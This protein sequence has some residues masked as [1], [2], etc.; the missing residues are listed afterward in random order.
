MKQ[1]IQELYTYFIIFLKEQCL[2]SIGPF[3]IDPVISCHTLQKGK[4]KLHEEWPFFRCG[5]EPPAVAEASTT[6]TTTPEEEEEEE[7]QQQKKAATTTPKDIW[8]TLLFS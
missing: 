8:K 3:L 7:Q 2:L 1:R 4:K 6:I 5:L